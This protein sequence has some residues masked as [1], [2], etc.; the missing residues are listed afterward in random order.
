[1]NTHR[2]QRARAG[3]YAYGRICACGNLKDEQALRCRRC[4]A[5]ERRDENA[6]TCPCGGPKSRQAARCRRCANE[7]LIGNQHA[8]GHAQPPSHP[9]R[10]RIAA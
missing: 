10:K 4:Y 6:R 2:W 5:D 7:R 1:M 3:D 9:W 8:A